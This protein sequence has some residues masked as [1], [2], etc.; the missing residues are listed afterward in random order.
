MHWT[1]TLA[2][3]AIAEAAASLLSLSW[4]FAVLIVMFIVLAT[5]MRVTM[6]T[7][8]A[9]AYATE[10]RLS[11]HVTATA[12]AVNLVANGGTIGGNVIVNGDHH[13]AGTL[14][15]AAGTLT[16][17]DAMHTNSTLYVSGN[18]TTN[19]THQVNGDHNVNGNIAGGTDVSASN[20]VNA[21]NGLNGNAVVVSSAF[22]N[23]SQLNMLQARGTGLTAAPTTYNQTWGNSVVSFGT[24]V[25]G[26]LQSANIFA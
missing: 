10:A 26:S 19:G 12:P 4:G 15:G 22:I 2:M 9:K 11:A 1:A 24:Q 5:R 14:Y 18:A 13:V 21:G 23:G 20:N 8:T 25:N 16:V 6:A 17:G 7:V 3:A